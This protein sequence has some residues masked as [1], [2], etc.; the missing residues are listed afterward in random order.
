[1][2]AV[3]GGL[4]GAEY[5]L[6]AFFSA[7]AAV[8]GYLTRRS[9]KRNAT[10]LD[11][12][13]HQ[14]NGQLQEKIRSAIVESVTHDELVRAVSEEAIRDYLDGLL[15]AHLANDDAGDGDILNDSTHITERRRAARDDPG[16]HAED[17]SD[18]C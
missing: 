13:V 15:E 5:L 6:T 14:T 7:I 8:F 17:T 18:D 1:M 10:K 16:L 4:G 11:T 3:P 9:A 12:V 2:T